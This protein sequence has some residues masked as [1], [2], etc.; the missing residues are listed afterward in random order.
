MNDTDTDSL[1]DQV[2]LVTGA[3]R[4]IGRAI[5]IELGRLGMRVA[6]NYRTNEQAAATAA[7]EA[8]AAGAREAR[9]YAA[10][11]GDADSDRAMAAAVAKELGP[12]DVLVNN[13]GIQRPVMLHKMTDDDWR[14]VMAVNIDSVF[15]LC[16]AVLPGMRDRGR[17]QIVNIA[18]ASSFMGQRGASSYVTSKHAL[19]GLTRALA[20]ETAS[21]GIRVNAV[22]PGL[23]DTDLVAGL[24]P[25]QLASLLSMVPMRRLGRPEEVA[26]MVRFVLTQAT[27]STGNVFHVG[28]GVVM[29]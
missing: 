28:G 25:E 18:S 20:L 22:A 15:Y 3:S 6:I 11:V 26:A 10:D 1:R 29:S 23:T 5:A 21:K 19:I 24:K 7:E 12:I 8:L 27:Y 17:G 13:A 2:A 4:G 9:I 16:R 14:Q